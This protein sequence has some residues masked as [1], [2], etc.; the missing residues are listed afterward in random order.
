MCPTNDPPLNQ[1]L[2]T[3]LRRDI[4]LLSFVRKLLW[5][6]LGEISSNVRQIRVWRAEDKFVTHVT[7]HEDR[8]YD[9]ECATGWQYHCEDEECF[10]DKV[11]M[12]IEIC[13]RPLVAPPPP[14]SIPLVDCVPIYIECVV[15][16]PTDCDDE[17]GAV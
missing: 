13:P 8:A 4:E 17:E 3:M 1:Q 2:D 11:D 6:M 12:R 16:D 10:R 15:N 7:L 14:A 9:R 5:A